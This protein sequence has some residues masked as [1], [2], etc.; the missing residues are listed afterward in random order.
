MERYEAISIIN[1]GSRK[2]LFIIKYISDSGTGSV[3][4]QLGSGSYE[5]SARPLRK[6]EVDTLK[7][8]LESTTKSDELKEELV[9][10]LER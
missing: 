8:L 4:L 5:I 9:K 10:K 6:D 1:N 7:S 3:E 2:A